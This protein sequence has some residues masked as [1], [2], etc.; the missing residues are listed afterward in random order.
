MIPHLFNWIF[1][2]ITFIKND[3]IS[4]LIKETCL[5]NGWV[6]LQ[7]TT[8][9]QNAELWSLVSVYKFIHPKSLEHPKAQWTWQRRGRRVPIDRRVEDLLWNCVSH[10]RSYTHKVSPVWLHNVSWTRAKTDI[11]NCMGESPQASAWHKAYWNAESWRKSLPQRT[12]Q[13]FIQY[14]RSL[15]T[16]T[17]VAL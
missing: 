3:L 9:N 12:R 5:C 8:T 13:L 2:S 7:R 4:S 10:V 1:G 14:Q 16:L 6:P 15:K 11:P 17:Q